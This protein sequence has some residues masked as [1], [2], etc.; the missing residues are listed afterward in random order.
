MLT[1]FDQKTCCFK[2]SPALTNSDIIMH[3]SAM[4]VYD[5]TVYRQGDEWVDGCDYT[6]E[7]TDQTTGRYECSER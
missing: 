2:M 3:F 4:C 5:N 1:C 7:C 6:C